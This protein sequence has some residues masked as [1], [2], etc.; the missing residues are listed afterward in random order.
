M[1][2]KYKRQ[3]PALLLAIAA[4]QNHEIR[5]EQFRLR[6]AA[7]RFWEMLDSETVRLFVWP[8]YTGL[9]A[10]GIYATFWSAPVQIVETV[11]GHT[12]YNAW[13]WLTIAGTLSVM[14]GLVLRH[15]G[16]PIGKITNPQAERDYIALWLQTGGH[17]CMFCVLLAFEV[18]GVNGSYWGQATFSLFAI[19]PYVLGV[20]FLGMQTA[21]KLW[22]IEQLQRGG[23]L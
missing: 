6:R 7:H 5:K 18:A 14:T 4:G 2:Q 8:F 9:L 10:W 13:V 11:M 23:D 22:R 21:R 15:G 19:A 1:I 20:L 12:V 16:A 3:I 17:A